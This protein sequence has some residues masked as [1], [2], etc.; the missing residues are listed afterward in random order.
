ML[1]L[2][3]NIIFISEISTVLGVSIKATTNGT[4]VSP[5]VT[6]HF[7]CLVSGLEQKL[8]T[9]VSCKFFIVFIH[10]IPGIN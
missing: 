1:F 9:Q 10:H 6:I 3:E 4:K 5:G 2:T 7:T 8:M